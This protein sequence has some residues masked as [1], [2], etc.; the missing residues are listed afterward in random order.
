ME[1]LAG[2][3]LKNA[4][5]GAC[6][7]KAQKLAPLAVIVPAEFTARTCQYFRPEVRPVR[8]TLVVLPTEVHTVQLGDVLTQYWY[9]VAPSTGGPAQGKASRLVD[10]IIW[11]DCILKNGPGGTTTVKAPEISTVGENGA[12]D[13]YCRVPAN[14]ATPGVNPLIATLVAGPHRDPSCTTAVVL[15]QYSQR[16]TLALGVQLNVSAVGWLVALLAGLTLK[17][18]PMSRDG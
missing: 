13:S 9:E 11:L 18:V 12:V 4:P 3:T 10:G 15:T 17:R 14:N 7:V 6:T 2:A 16:I 5:G 8:A 1:L